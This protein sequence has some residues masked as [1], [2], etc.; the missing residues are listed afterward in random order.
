MEIQQQILKL[1]DELNQHNYNYYVL[2]QP[3]VSDYDF[4]LK[5]KELQ[6]LEDQYP[7]FADEHSPTRRVGGAITKNFE[8]VAHEQRMYSLDNSYSKEDVLEWESRVKK[9]IDGAVQ[10]VCELKYDGASISLTYENGTLLKAVTRGDGVQ[11]DDVTE[12]IKTIR[13]VPLRLKGEYP[14]KFEIRG[15]IVLP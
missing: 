12:N 10:F 13:S 3:S 4:D 5:L 1:R 8:T 14:P 9:M 7:E 11:G 15:E 6:V 2:D